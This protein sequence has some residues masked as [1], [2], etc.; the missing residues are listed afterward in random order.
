[1]NTLHLTLAETAGLFK[2]TQKTVRDWIGRGLPTVRLGSQGRGKKTLLNLPDAVRWWFAENFER[3]ELDR[4]RT[5]QASE[6]AN[7]LSIDNAAR[8][9]EVVL[10]AVVSQV[11]NEWAADVSARLDGLAGRVAAEF[12]SI[13]DAGI[14]RQRLLAE[15]RAVRTASA[16]HIT[17]FFAGQGR[18]AAKQP[19]AR[20]A[21]R[22]K[23][24]RR[25]RRPA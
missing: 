22:T 19:R 5:R 16:D 14:I 7:K 9:G 2:V 4:A 10:A 24:K 3:L 23:P 17:R 6:T 1:M 13:D 8:R 12:A 11:W 21:K 15:L 20:R 25:R 18:A